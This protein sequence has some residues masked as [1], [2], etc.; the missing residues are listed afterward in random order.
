MALPFSFKVQMLYHLPSPSLIIRSAK[1]ADMISI[2]GGGKIVLRNKF[3][4]LCFGDNR[5]DYLV[6]ILLLVEFA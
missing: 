5:Q 1:M 4:R 3:G 2:S 6:H